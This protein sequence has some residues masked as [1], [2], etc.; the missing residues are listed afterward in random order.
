MQLLQEGNGI[1]GFVNGSIP[2]P[3]QFDDSASDDETVENNPHVSDAY[4][5][6][7]IHDKALMTL[8]SAT[9]SSSALSCIIG[10]QS[11]NE[12]WMNF[13]ERF[14]SVTRTS[15]VQLKI[16]LQNI[17]KGPESVDVY[18]QRIKESRDQL[19]AAGVTISDE[20]IVIVALRGLPSEYN[21]IKAVIRG[22]EN[23]VS[24]KELR[25]QL[26]AEESTLDE[27]TKQIPLMSAMYTQASG[28]HFD[29]GESS[30][31][32][33]VPPMVQSFSGYPNFMSPFMPVSNMS[34]LG[35]P[36]FQKLPLPPVSNVPMAFVTQQSSGSYNN[37]RGNNFRG[38]NHK[39]KGQG[40][41]F[42]GHNS[43]G[44]YNGTGGQ[45]NG[46]HTSGGQYNGSGGYA[47]PQHYTVS[48]SFQQNATPLPIS[49]TYNPNQI[50]QICDRKGH[51]ALTCFQHGC[52]I[53]HRVSHVAATCFDRNKT[54]SGFSSPFSP[55]V[56]PSMPTSQHNGPYGQYGQV[57]MWNP[58]CSPQSMVS[59]NHGSQFPS[60][61]MPQSHA[62]L[63][64]HTGL[65]SSSSAPPQDFWLLDSKATNHMTSDV[66]NLHM[67]T[68][69]P[70]TD[71]VTSASGEGLLI[72]HIGP[73][74][75]PTK[76][77]NFKLPSVLHVPKLSQ[78]LLSMNQLCKDNKCRCI[79]DDVSLCIQDKVTA[80]MLFHRLSNNAVYPIPMLKPQR[81]LSHGSTPI[82]YVGQKQPSSFLWHCRLGH[83]TQ[84]I[85][86]AALSKSHIPFTCNA[87]SH[88][89]KACLQGKFTK[90]H[91]PVIASKSITPFEVIH[92]DVW[93]PSPSI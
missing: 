42:H 51:S 26:K 65:G 79:F 15:I 44:Q 43:G 23:L 24:L 74:F 40:K 6:W 71:T 70:S 57:S 82:A 54:F 52:Q 18:L 56:P 67:A 11:S 36:G 87:Q 59:Q 66:S 14:S 55:G 75:L 20:D 90:L 68:S 32:K 33:S 63:A 19:A 53:C 10:C 5:V 47:Q 83:P 88:L 89:C 86:T 58:F 16:D 92:T 48:S 12:M 93:G 1:V 30:R 17:K 62:P 2:C 34:L 31:T 50:C 41:K 27:A 72:K 45:Y 46:G 4:Q 49:L 25:S 60:S 84:S 85:V 91:F 80:R 8:I 61:A 13:R 37:F 21:T 76:S 78:H 73:S 39:G 29:H 7:K 81:S 28:S 64:M 35:F 22:R 77:H 69:Y 38:N 3:A 9:L